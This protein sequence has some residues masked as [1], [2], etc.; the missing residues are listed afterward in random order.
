MWRRCW[1]SCRRP[2]WRGVEFHML[3]SRSEVGRRIQSFVF[4]G[5]DDLVHQDLGAVTGPI[6]V[7]ALLVGD[8]YLRQARRMANACRQPGPGTLVHPWLGEL[9]V[10]LSEPAS[11]TL[12]DRRRRVAALEMTFEVYGSPPVPAVDTLGQVLDAIDEA[13]AEARAMLRAVLA[14]LALPLAAAR[15]LSDFASAAGSSWRYGLGRL[16]G[17]SLAL[18]GAGPALSALVAIGSLPLSAALPEA[19]SA[20]IEGVPDAIA[21]AAILPPP[22]A[23]GPGGSTATITSALADR[24]Q[25][26]LDPRLA[27]DVLLVAADQQAQMAMGELPQLG[28]AAQS[29][30]VA[31]A[32]SVAA[33][34]PYESQQEAMAVRARLDGALAA[35]AEVAARLSADRP[36]VAGPV[37]RALVQL[38]L[39]ANRDLTA[40]TGRLP[41]VETLTPPGAVSVWLVAQHLAGSELSR[42]LP[43]AEDVLSRNRIR[44]GWAVPAAP[45]EVLR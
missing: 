15:Y 39:V 22:P 33:D 34:I 36:L 37:W 41:V 5:R 26:Q 18:A 21:A 30:A 19:V 14:P 29:H 13:R 23:I 10:V 45:L 38:R 20:G 16:S 7:N 27:L 31:L 42:L 6:Q 17:S 9:A 2:P 43:L 12:E 3:D 11:I 8:D 28:L 4:P 24:D 35:A 44:R 1:R 32:V 25:A 40:R